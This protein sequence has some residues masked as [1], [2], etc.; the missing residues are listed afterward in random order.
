MSIKFTDTHICENCGKVFEWNYFEL[1]RQNIDSP[2]YIFKL[3]PQE[4]TLAY[5][6]H[7]RDN[8]IYDIG[9]NCPHCDYDNHFT[10]I[11]K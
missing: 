11:V 2:Q 10:Y 1:K 9:V 7:E 4:R 6:C 8:L 3:M 5:S